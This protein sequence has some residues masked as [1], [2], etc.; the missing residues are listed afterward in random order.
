M[1]IKSH[2]LKK[3]HRKLKYLDL[4]WPPADGT[5]E[6]GSGGH[7]AKALMLVGPQQVGPWRQGQVGVELQS[8]TEETYCKG[9]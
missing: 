1:T 4:A 7:R 9:A 6:A 8:Q 5:L 2:K 3:R